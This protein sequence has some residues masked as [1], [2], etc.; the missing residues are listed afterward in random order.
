VVLMLLV[1]KLD[2][3]DAQF[4]DKLL[5]MLLVLKPNAP[6]GPDVVLLFDELCIWSQCISWLY[7]AELQEI[8]CIHP[9]LYTIVIHPWF[10][11]IVCVDV[12]RGCIM[13]NF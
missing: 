8:E 13:Q 11:T 6:G 1:P 7:N 12:F 5:L 4:I 2:A 9:W 3:P 10:Y